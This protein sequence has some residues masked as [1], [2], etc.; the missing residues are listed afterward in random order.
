MMSTAADIRFWSRVDKSGPIPSHVPHLGNC[1]I[2]RGSKARG[3][4]HFAE[5][6]ATG[7]L[8]TTPTHRFAWRL[9]Y[10]PIPEG[11]FVLHKCDVRACVRP[12]HLFLG[13]A[14]DNADDMIAKGRAK[15]IDESGARRV[16]TKQVRGTEH[17]SAKLDESAV[18]AIRDAY[19]AAEG[20][21]T[22]LASR[23]GTSWSNVRLIVKGRTWKHLLAQHPAPRSGS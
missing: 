22:E 13:T 16:G 23:F 17:G 3:Y 7:K 20:S 1:W 5:R 14:K 15:L 2:W 8:G 9:A 4:G 19:A 12:D 6:R 11:L 21:Y 10:G 18:V